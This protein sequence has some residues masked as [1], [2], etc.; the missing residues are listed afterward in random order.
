[1]RR[2]IVEAEKQSVRAVSKDEKAVRLSTNSVDD[3]IDAF[4]LKFEQRSKSDKLTE[5]FRK[6]NLSFLLEAEGDAAAPEGEGAGGEEPSDK[7]TEPERKISLD[8]RRFTNQ[9]ARLVMNSESLLDPGTVIINRAAEFLTENYD[10]QHASE[11]LDYLEEKFNLVPSE[12]VPSDDRPPT[13][14]AVG[15][16]GGGGGAT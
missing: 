11:M 14:P 12:N 16:F 1:M 4:I 13:P 10:E 8:L 7:K 5:A 9:V 6:R 2:V 15:A 3:Q